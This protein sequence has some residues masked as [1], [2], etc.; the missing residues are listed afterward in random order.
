MNDMAMRFNGR[1]IN[2]SKRPANAG[3][4][5]SETG[6]RFGGWWNHEAVDKD[7]YMTFDYGFFEDFLRI[8]EEY[9][10]APIDGKKLLTRLTPTYYDKKKGCEVDKD[11]TLAV[12]RGEDGV[13]CFAWK[14][15]KQRY[16][17]IVFEVGKLGSYKVMVGT[18]EE[19]RERS[20]AE[21]SKERAL[22]WIENVRWLKSHHNPAAKE[23]AAETPSYSAPSSGGDSG[24]SDFGDEFDF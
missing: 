9:A 21:Y 13:I 11:D 16:P 5:F 14:S 17:S 8:L 15:N 1:M 7:P 18:G 4:S 3:F 10:L 6:V 24:G 19:A 22:G 23:Q 2:G 20:P 12:M